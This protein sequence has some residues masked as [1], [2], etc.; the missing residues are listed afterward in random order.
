MRGLSSVPMFVA[1][2][3]CVTRC[4]TRCSVEAS[5]EPTSSNR[6]HLHCNVLQPG[7]ITDMEEYFRW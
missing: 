3:L 2:L 7:G 5:R 4:V 1:S 6:P